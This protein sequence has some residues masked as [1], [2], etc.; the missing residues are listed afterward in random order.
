MKILNMCYYYSVVMYG[1]IVNILI[2]SI[3]VSCVF[4]YKFLVISQWNYWMR[5][6]PMFHKMNKQSKSIMYADLS[7]QLYTQQSLKI[8]SEKK[9]RPEWVSNP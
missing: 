8:R 9:I 1:R 2:G 3:T 5:P 4:F 6:I 7:L